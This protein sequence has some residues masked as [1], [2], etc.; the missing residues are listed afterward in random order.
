MNYT[1]HFIIEGK[2][3]GAATFSEQLSLEG[4]RTPDS[5]AYICPVCGDLWARVPV[6]NLSGVTSRFAPLSR[7][8]R[9]H[10]EH[11]L[12]VPGSIGVVWEQGFD[13]S[14]PDEVVRWEFSRHM[15]YYDKEQ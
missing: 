11:S 14:L 1:R 13:E 8:C 15:E 4:P 10:F 3:L 2:H 9:K 5:F 12:A 6:E 7:T